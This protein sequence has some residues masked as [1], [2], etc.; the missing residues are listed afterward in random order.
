MHRILSFLLL[1][2]LAVPAAAAPRAFSVEVS[3]HGAPIVLIPGLSCACA[4]WLL[5][6]AWFLGF[7]QLRHRNMCL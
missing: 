2:A 6:G 3:G 4:A 7:G 5:F 1:A